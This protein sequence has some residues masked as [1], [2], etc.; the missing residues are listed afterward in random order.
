MR[1]R[2]GVRVGEVSRSIFFF[3]G[4][5]LPDAMARDALAPI[6]SLFFFLRG[7]GWMLL[8]AMARDSLAP[9]LAVCESFLGVI[10]S[11]ARRG[12]ASLQLL[13]HEALSD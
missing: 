12:Q 7:Q 13:V 9:N 1:L 6:F 5:M 2:S 11:A 3:S 4:C 8:D 10:A